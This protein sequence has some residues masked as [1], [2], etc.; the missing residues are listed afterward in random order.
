M[1]LVPVLGWD[2]RGDDTAEALDDRLLP[3]LRAIASSKSL[4]GAVKERGISYR[5]A[6]GLLRDYGKKFGEPLALLE[7][8]RGATLTAC[9][10][11]LV[12][13]EDGATRRL[14]RLLPQLEATV[15]AQAPA[16]RKHADR[17]RLRLAAS[18]DLLLAGLVAELP[19]GYGL[20]LD[21]AFMGSVH[22]IKEFVN[23]HVDLA[24][25]HFP[26]RGQQRQARQA[27]LAGLRARGDRLICLADRD[28]GLILPSGNPLKV[29]NLADVVRRRLRFVNR[30]PGSGTRLLIDGMI[31]AENIA[32]NEIVGYGNEEFTHRAVAATVAS[33][34]A[35]VGFGVRAAAAEHKL[36]FVPLVQ[37]R[38]VFAL[39]SKSLESVAVA[40][41]LQ[42]LKSPLLGTLA[43][44]FT[45]YGIGA[46]GSIRSVAAA[47][48]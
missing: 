13:I 25:F 39:R 16:G 14:A 4:A 32:R 43:R 6:W 41:L 38:Y 31:E 33:G 8:G 3:L 21:V 7:R 5:A 12:G 35:D 42:V 19:A 30:Q 9:G 10:R 29:R 28:Q 1:R 2:L 24:G 45:G 34:V 27:V 15:G 36:A 17:Q 11:R 47:W 18:H 22:A 20:T 26:L 40:R 48:S 37:E 23:G 44:R 46:T